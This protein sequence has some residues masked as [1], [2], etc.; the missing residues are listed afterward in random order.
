[1]SILIC[2]L[3]SAYSGSE[4][5]HSPQQRSQLQLV[6]QAGDWNSGLQVSGHVLMVLRR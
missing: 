1:M 4:W 5:Y 3:W 6:H 2:V